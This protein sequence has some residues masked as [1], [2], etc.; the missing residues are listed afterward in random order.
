MQA[1]ID[2]CMALV[3][4]D[5]DVLTDVETAYAEDAVTAVVYSLMCRQ[6]GNSQEA[7]W[8]A[9]CACEAVGYFATHREEVM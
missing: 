8:S 5:D 9:Q 6:N 2:T 1:S 4:Q 7:M 3:P